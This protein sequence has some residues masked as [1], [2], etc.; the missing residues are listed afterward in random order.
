MTNEHRTTRPHS[1][2]TCPAEL[3]ITS[4]LVSWVCVRG[5]LFQLL[6][7]PAPLQPRALMR[8]IRRHQA[9]TSNLATLRVC[10]AESRSNQSLSKTLRRRQSPQRPCILRVGDVQIRSEAE[11]RPVHDRV[12][13]NL[14]QA[15]AEM[16]GFKDVL[17][18]A[19][20]IFPGP[21]VCVQPQRAMAKVQR[22]NII[23]PKNVI[24]MTMR[25]Q[26]RVEMLEPD[27]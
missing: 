5:G 22:P 10:P 8:R 16:S 25:D 27:A 21:L 23:E 18:N 4:V 3:R 7:I 15:A 20:N 1:P 6:K 13:N 11:R 12:R 19:P 2:S 26:H 17:E 14:R 9:N 24:G